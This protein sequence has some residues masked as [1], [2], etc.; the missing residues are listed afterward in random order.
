MHLK[1]RPASESAVMVVLTGKMYQ[2]CCWWPSGTTGSAGLHHRGHISWHPGRISSSGLEHFCWIKWWNVNAWIALFCSSVRV[3]TFL[4]IALQIMAFAF[5]LW[6]DVLSKSK[7]ESTI[8]ESTHAKMLSA[9]KS[10]V[11]VG[12]EN[13]ALDSCI[14]SI[15]KIERVSQ[16][17]WVALLIEWNKLDAI[18]DMLKDIENNHYFN[19]A[20]LNHA[21]QVALENDRWY[22]Y[23]ISRWFSVVESVLT[24]LNLP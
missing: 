7:E 12:A 9:K 23:S 10:S 24:W 19:K 13:H 11:P 2:D 20:S 16:S 21:L 5:C 14:E 3:Q 8:G 18:R 15:I 22:W 6:S 17:L 4:V 1:S